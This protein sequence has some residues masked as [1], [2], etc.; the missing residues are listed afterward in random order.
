MTDLLVDPRFWGAI[1]GAL[2]LG[3]LAGL[4]IMALLRGNDQTPQ[5]RDP[6]HG[7]RQ[8]LAAEYERQRAEREKA[9]RGSV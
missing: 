1:V 4:L 9:S 7:F 6:D 5:A 8:R 3:F 2:F